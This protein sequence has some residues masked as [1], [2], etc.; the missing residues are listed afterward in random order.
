MIQAPATNV[1]SPQDLAFAMPGGLASLST[2]GKWR[3]ADHLVY[4]EDLLLD[5]ANGK[6]TR[7]IINMPPRH[8]KSMFTSHYFPAW[9]LGRYPDKRVI[10]ASYESTFAASWGAAARDVL[11]ELGPDVFGITVDDNTQAKDNWKIANH[12]G[13]MMTAGAGGPITGKG[14][15]L[16]IIDDPIKNQDDA[17]SAVQ[18]EKI[19]DWYRSVA[20]TRLA[21]NAAIII[22]MT[23]WAHNDLVGQLF[24]QQAEGMG[25]IWHRA[26]LPALAEDNDPLGR[27]PGGA[28]WPSQYDEKYLKRIQDIQGSFW[29]GAMYQQ[30]PVP[31]GGDIL[32]VEWFRRYKTRP[33][34]G[35]AEQIILSLDTAQ[36]EKELNDYTVIGVWLV[37]ED[38][39][40]LVDVIRDR[41]NQPRLI[42]LTKNLHA[43]WK[44]NA[45]LI[46]DKGSGTGLLQHLEEETSIGAIAIE[47]TTDKAIR[48]QNESAAVEAGHVY[49]PEEGSQPWLY[50]F[51]QEIFGFPNTVHKDHVDMF[52]Q[53]LWYM[54]TRYGNP[55]D[56]W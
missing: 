15:D 22:I 4:L 50:D 8:G 19:W 46:E 27:E 26:I 12:L 38:N 44:P 48:M 21:P 35:Q 53:F 9:F 5:V 2:D 24:T 41:M 3:Y 6:I 42:A 1:Y 32:K 37:Y 31:R 16:F 23:R 28:L 40:Y 29:F 17:L 47:P 56:L 30:K 7:L 25:D 13:G 52:S 39:F 11:L 49:L 18:Q 55:I 51:E 36:K 14:A 34:R 54:R 10:L 33:F 20:L 45:V 43:K